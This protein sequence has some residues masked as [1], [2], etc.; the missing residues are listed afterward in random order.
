MEEHHL[1]LDTFADARRTW[2][3]LI[4]LQSDVVAGSGN[5]NKPDLIELERRVAAHRVAIDVLAETLEA[6]GADPAVDRDLEDRTGIS[7]RESAR[8]EARERRDH[9]PLDAGSPPPEDAAGRVGEQPLQDTRDRHTSHKAGS[10]SIAQKEAT[11][12]YPDRSMPASRKVAGAFG[13]E[14]KGKAR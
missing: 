1:L 9:P 11:S 7:N 6:E 3:D 14:P 5:L 4:S 2:D 10:R 8:D 13:K 12:R